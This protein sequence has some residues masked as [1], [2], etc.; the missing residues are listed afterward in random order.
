M[1]TG[2]AQAALVSPSGA[3]SVTDH[4][5]TF[6]SFNRWEKEPYHCTDADLRVRASVTT[7]DV[8]GSSIW[9]DSITVWLYGD[10]RQVDPNGADF[11]WGGGGYALPYYNATRTDYGD[12]IEE[13]WTVGAWI[14]AS[15]PGAIL[16][17]YSK[18]QPM[19][20]ENNWCAGTGQSVA[21]WQ[22]RPA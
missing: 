20:G 4:A 19:P 1:I 17:S 16:Q 2:Q 21:I 7:G 22:I 13:S 15:G 3:D 18:P 8:N 10:R 5:V 6:L 11:L 9:V 14:D 12:H